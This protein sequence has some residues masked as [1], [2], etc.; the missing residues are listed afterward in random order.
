M[1]SGLNIGHWNVPK[2][3]RSTAFDLKLDALALTLL[4]VSVANP[5]MRLRIQRM[6][7]QMLRFDPD[8]AH[9]G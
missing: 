8:S 5:R 3:K 9:L 2:G 4:V 7:Y 6:E 1:G